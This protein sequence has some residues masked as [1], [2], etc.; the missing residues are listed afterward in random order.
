M[1]DGTHYE[2]GIKVSDEKLE[3]LNIVYN[4]FHKDWNYTIFPRDLRN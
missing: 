3:G 1:A 4:S 2:T